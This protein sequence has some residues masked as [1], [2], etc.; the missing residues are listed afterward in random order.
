MAVTQ[1]I[2]ATLSDVLGRKPCLYAAYAFFFAGSIVFALAKSMGR[3]VASRVLQGFGGG[4]LDVL[5]EIIVTDMTT[6]QECSLY[7]GL[8]AIHTAL[9]SVLGPTIAGIV[10]SLVFWRWLGWIN[11]PLLGI[12][13]LLTAFF[14]RLRSLTT[15][16]SGLRNIDWIGIPLSTTGIVLFALPVSWADNL[17]AWGSFR[18]LLPLVLGTLILAVFVFYER[19]PSAPIMPYRIFSSKT[20]SATL[21]GV[22]LHGM[23]LY[24]L[25]Q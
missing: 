4:G 16:L 14:L 20:A 5:S 18:T 6:L 22:F 24:S 10:S 11:L 1:P 15:S 19:R 7:L 13:F 12:S 9:G 25:L 2:Y 3:M 23:S 8:M 17:Y 21:A